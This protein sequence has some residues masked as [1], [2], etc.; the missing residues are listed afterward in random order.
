MSL[1]NELIELAE[2]E[3]S[4]GFYS[5]QTIKVA[6][7]TLP[8]T[9]QFTIHSELSDEL[10]DFGKDML[11]KGL[12]RLPYEYTLIYWIQPDGHKG[13]CQVYQGNEPDDIAGLVFSPGSTSNEW[14]IMG[15]CFR[16]GDDVR[17]Q[18]MREA[19]DKSPIRCVSFSPLARTD[20]S[21]AEARM[22]SEWGGWWSSVVL[23]TCSILIS[24]SASIQH[25]PRPDALNLKRTKLGKRS[26]DDYH[27]VRLSHQG[28]SGSTSA[29]KDR[30]PSRLHWR[31]GHIRTLS[32]GKL[33]PVSPTIVGTGGKLIAK[34]YIYKN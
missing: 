27:V 9:H 17:E 5:D 22:V 24:K 10:I 12:L 6:L 14:Q 8:L 29:N 30:K 32:S 33:V 20:L 19:A 34:E 18:D 4:A 23:A 21:E 1:K 13:A 11:G 16:V 7:E 31:R 2:R 25:I 15:W 28:G 26:I 3:K